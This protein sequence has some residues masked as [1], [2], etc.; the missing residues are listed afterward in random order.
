MSRAIGGKPLAFGGK[1]LV[2]GG[3]PLVFGGKPL[4]FGNKL[5]FGPSIRNLLDGRCGARGYRRQA[6]R[7]DDKR[8]R[9]LLNVDVHVYR[10][11]DLLA[12]DRLQ[13]ASARRAS[14]LGGVAV[15]GDE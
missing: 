1:P 7:L 12:L 10:W 14:W 6:V 15:E 11:L 9:F 4:V 5:F 8:L 2:F 13:T 3:K